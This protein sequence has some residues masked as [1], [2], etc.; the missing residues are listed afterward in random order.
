[1]KRLN[2]YAKERITNYQRRIYRNLDK[3]TRLGVFWFEVS[4]LLFKSFA[5]W[6][7]NWITSE[8][9]DT[10][11]TKIIRAKSSIPKYASKEEALTLMNIKPSDILTQI[12]TLKIRKLKLKKLIWPRLLQKLPTHVLL[13]SWKNNLWQVKHQGKIIKKEQMISLLNEQ[14]DIET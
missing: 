13:D 10:I 11:F 5:D 12:G 9:I 8:Q 7:L 3:S 2:L 4:K 6:K 1:L 14:K